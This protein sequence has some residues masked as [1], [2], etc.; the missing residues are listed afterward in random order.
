MDI[1]LVED[2]YRY[3]KE[4]VQPLETHIESIQEDSTAKAIITLRIPNTDKTETGTIFLRKFENT[5]YLV[6]TQI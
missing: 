1:D 3:N 5:W 6:D 4:A 2:L